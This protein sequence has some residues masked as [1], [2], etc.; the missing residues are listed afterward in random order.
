MN[1]HGLYV[2]TTNIKIRGVR[3]GICYLS[4]L[5]R[6]IR[7]QDR[8]EA[9]EIIQDAPRVAAHTYW[10]VDD[11]GAVELECSATTS[12]RRDMAAEPILQTNHCLS[13][14]HQRG[15]AEPPHD[16]SLHRLARARTLLVEQPPSGGHD[17]ESLRRLMEDRAGEILAINRYPE[18]GG[19]ATTNACVIAE[20]G[21]RRLWACRG[22]ADRGAWVE[23]PFSRVTADAAG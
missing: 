9:A 2:G 3:P 17:V 16:S 22:P 20:P 13:A 21:A 11:A 1:E 5:H 4:L 18:D 23:L 14:R 12:D 10:M 19:Y 6:A 15:E 7:C 8:L